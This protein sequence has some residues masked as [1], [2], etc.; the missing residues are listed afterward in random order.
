MEEM[1]RLASAGPE[2]TNGAEPESRPVTRAPDGD[3]DLARADAQAVDTVNQELSRHRASAERAL[4]EAR[5]LLA[6]QG[7]AEELERQR[8]TELR[9][10]LAAVPLDRHV[11][12]GRRRLSTRSPRPAGRLLARSR[13]PRRRWFPTAWRCS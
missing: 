4:A 2:S 5:A 12:T 6:R 9:C 8:S 11:P 10:D 13:W 3:R 7:A 1:R